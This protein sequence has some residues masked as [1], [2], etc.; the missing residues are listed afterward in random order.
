MMNNKNK[1][2]LNILKDYQIERGFKSNHKYF[3]FVIYYTDKI[4]YFTESNIQDTALIK[5]NEE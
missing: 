5:L 4:N 1:I 2:Y 3:Y